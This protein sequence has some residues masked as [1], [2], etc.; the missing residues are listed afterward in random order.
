MN[1]LLLRKLIPVFIFLL[2]ACGGGEGDEATSD[3]FTSDVLPVS[4]NEIEF[5]THLD[6][7]EKLIMSYPKDWRRQ[8]HYNLKGTNVLTV[9]IEPN[10]SSADTFQEKLFLLKAESI[11]ELT[12]QYITVTQDISTEST[13]ISGGVGVKTIYDAVVEDD[14]FIAPKSTLLRMMQISFEFNNTA[15]ALLYIAERSQFNKNSEI[16]NFISGSLVVGQEIMTNFQLNSDED[17]PGKPA[18]SNDGENFLI[19]SCRNIKTRPAKMDLVGRILKKGRSLGEEFFI[20]ESLPFQRTE[21]SSLK[22]GVVFDGSQYLVT[23]STKLNNS[24]RVLG[25]KI[26]VNGEVL[27]NNPIDISQNDTGA[28]KEPSVS[29]D[30]NRTLI[31][32]SNEDVIEGRFIDLNGNITPSFL[33]AEDLSNTYNNNSNIHGYTTQIAYSNNQFMVV[34]SPYRYDQ[35]NSSGLILGQLLDLS[36]NTL[37]PEP[38][39]IRA[40]S[41]PNVSLPYGPQIASDGDNFLVAWFE[42]DPDD[43]EA[44]IYT[45]HFSNSAELI[46]NASKLPVK[47]V[48]SAIDTPYQEDKIDISKKYLNL[49]YN[50]GNYMLLWSST[51]Y[52]QVDGVYGV[53]VSK[54]LDKISRAIPI[55]GIRN[56]NISS[57]RAQKPSQSSISYSNDQTIII[58]A[59]RDGYANGIEGWYIDENTF[60]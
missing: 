28:A 36:G 47:I 18:I 12:G 3:D 9:F 24:V 53:K 49:A 20:H 23:Y 33:I 48:S 6:Q 57:H 46:D 34:W 29:F 13:H 44:S 19:I 15:Y 17:Q 39:V 45:K 5:L 16:I 37:K 60:N 56:Y 14:E 21:C 27:D 8:G 35:F 7:T 30:G 54:N 51:T 11:P 2:T 40:N 52:E 38:I 59:S 50:K 32:W 31:V 42:K 22:Y 1:S 55:A 26:S 4:P 43:P 25:K 58:W 41:N 10:D